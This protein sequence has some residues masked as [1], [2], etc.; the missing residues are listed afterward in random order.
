MECYKWVIGDFSSYAAPYKSDQNPILLPFLRHNKKFGS[1]HSVPSPW[2]Y[3][4]PLYLREPC[5]TCSLNTNTLPIRRTVL[6]SVAAWGLN[7]P[8]KWGGCNSV[9]AYIEQSLY[10]MYY[11][12]CL[13]HWRSP[14]LTYWETFLAPQLGQASLQMHPAATVEASGSCTW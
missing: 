2:S 1:V 6:M 7:A 4:T 8:F 10:C 9:A 13:Q 5:R 3:H 11:C 12:W 14:L